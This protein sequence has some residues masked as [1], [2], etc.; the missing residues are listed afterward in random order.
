MTALFLSRILSSALM[1]MFDISPVFAEFALEAL[2]I[3]AV[4]QRLA[5]VGVAGGYHEVEYLA[6]V[7]DDQVQLEAVEPAHGAPALLR[8][9][10]ESAVGVRAL[11][12]AYPQCRGVGE[13]YAGA[14]A[15]EHVLDEQAQADGHFLLQLYEA[16]VGDHS[17]KQ[18]PH[19]T[20]HIANRMSMTII[21]ASLMRFGLFLCRL[22]SLRPSPREYL[23]LTLENSL[24]YSSAM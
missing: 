3:A 7:V 24:L 18:M 15:Q 19:V 12:V 20:A 13:A 8:K 9:A 5:V 21:S 1:S 4:P 2:Q 6:A 17:G 10:G 22:P 11:Y 16:A 23:C 14:L